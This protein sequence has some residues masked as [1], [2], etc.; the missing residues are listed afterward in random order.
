MS[1]EVTP[2]RF[3]VSKV[4]GEIVYRNVAEKLNQHLPDTIAGGVRREP[5]PDE[6]RNVPCLT[7]AQI[8][9]LAQAARKV[10]RH[11]GSAQ[12]IE[13]AIVHGERGVYLLQ[14]R[15]ETTETNRDVKPGAAPQ[16][17]DQDPVVSLLSG[18]QRSPGTRA[19]VPQLQ[20]AKSRHRAPFRPIGA[21]L[22]AN[23]PTTSGTGDGRS[24]PASSAPCT[25]HTL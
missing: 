6:L 7:D 19:A 3:L 9:E 11:Y 4:T 14:S 22:H 5:V 15:A 20:G 17:K 18:H 25:V 13:W 12:E 23:L 16:V 2:D 24:Y 10:E 21:R 1:G 8:I